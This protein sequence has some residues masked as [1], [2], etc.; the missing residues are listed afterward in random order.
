[1][2]GWGLVAGAEVTAGYSSDVQVASSRQDFAET[3]TG[4]LSEHT[5]E[6][7]SERE[8]VVSST[9][10][11]LSQRGERTRTTRQLKNVN[12]RRTLNFVFRELNQRYTTYVHLVDIRVAFS[13]GRPGSLREVPLSG[14][15]P[16][17]ESVLVGASV[18]ST[19][20]KILK[21]AGTAVDH[22]DEP[23][24][25]L[26]R[27]TLSDDGTE[28]TVEPAKLVGGQFP[29]PDGSTW[30]RFTP[31]PLS[32]PV[33]EGIDGVVVAEHHST[34]RTDSLLVEALMGQADALDDYAL[35]AQE[36]DLGLKNALVERE[37]IANAGLQGL[38]GE[39]R[40]EAFHA[41]FN[42]DGKLN[43]AIDH[44]GP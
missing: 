12:L 25:L 16:M 23:V 17:L 1:M 9:S 28:V 13:N 10:E 30:Y 27:V 31:G 24:P 44:G 22:E 11:H 29:V 38:N 19:C 40:A 35:G 43:V 37:T 3:V 2:W 32:A 33:I 4:A 6:A 21:M 8:S 5:S 7:N 39:Q 15:R 36:A 26:Q 20:Q 14:L 34:M 41:M 18:A 42:Q